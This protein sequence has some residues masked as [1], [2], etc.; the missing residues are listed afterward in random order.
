[1]KSIRQ[2]I[3]QPVKTLAGVMLVALAVAILVTCVGQ[4]F[5]TALTRADLENNYNT[6][7]LTTEKFKWNE[8]YNS[9][10]LDLPMEV[11]SWINKTVNSNLDIVKAVSDTGRMSAYIPELVPE[12]YTRYISTPQGTLGQINGEPYSCAILEITLDEIGTEIQTDML[13]IM[14][15]GTDIKKSISVACKG[16]VDRVIALQEGFNAPIGYT[17]DV[18][19][20]VFDEEALEDLDLQAGQ[21]YLIYG[22]DYFD[23][24]WY[25]RT[26]ISETQANFEQPFDESK[27]YELP[28]D[29]NAPT[30]GENS[31][32][33]I[34]NYYENTIG[35]GENARKTY[36]N[37]DSTLASLARSCR[38]TV[39]DASALPWVQITDR[40][41]YYKVNYDERTYHTGRDANYILGTGYTVVPAE[42]Y[43]GDYALPTFVP[44][45]GTAEEFLA[46]DEAELWRQA[47]ADMEIN[48]HAFP[49]LAVDKL[50]YQADFARQMV[51]VVDGRDFTEEELL[52]GKKVCVISETAAAA[53]DLAVGDTI[54]IQTYPTDYNIYPHK[55]N[56]LVI[57]ETPS[58]PSAAFYSHA[59]GFDGAPE[60]Y[61]I[62]GL[63]RHQSAWYGAS[64]YG[65]TPNTVFIPK[66]STT[67]TMEYDTEGI[68]RSYVLEND[69]LQEFQQIVTDAGYNGLF[70]YYDQGYGQLKSSLEAYDSV[71]SRALYVGIGAYL[72]I[73]ALFVILFP[74]RQRSALATMES[75]GA[76]RRARVGHV[77]AGSLGILL[78]GTAAGY[79]AGMLLWEDVTAELMQAVNVSLTLVSDGTAALLTAIVQLAAAALVTLLAALP[80][81]KSA[82]MKRK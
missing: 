14:V 5:S 58:Y 37:F 56:K 65:F 66:S 34:W 68:Y 62:V 53:N 52:N 19:F 45:D 20:R 39:Y 75:L 9:P 29:P 59:K 69:K 38:L 51:R 82:G 76:K 6:V 72:I 3:R 46:S 64:S 73:L 15:N 7:A 54:T 17:I 57:Y 18:I 79:L 77:M 16:T 26:I 60:T 10:T 42:E 43:I 32:G 12:N 8:A 30:H 71:S 70:V 33:I 61:T 36:V 2:L 78:P 55:E 23:Q 67:G 24:D 35:E 80:L 22:M 41:P 74:L 40:V 13:G 4:Y 31:L 49:V 63:Y 44:L 27:V 48:N 1:M 47:M 25:L 11:Y 81:T 50:G 21:R 28:P